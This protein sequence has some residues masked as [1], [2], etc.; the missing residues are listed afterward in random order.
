M[1]AGRA[2]QAE[3]IGGVGNAASGARLQSRGADLLFA[4][5]EEHGGKAVHPLLEQ[6]LDGFRRD[7]APGK[8]GA[9]RGDDYVDELV[10]DPRFHALPDRGD[11]VLDDRTLGQ[12]VAGRL[13]ALDQRG[14]RFIIGQPTR[15]GYGEYRDFQRHKLSARVDSA[16]PPSP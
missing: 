6:R 7:V 12:Y 9:A 1:G 2:R 16:H 15:V 10:V 13:D 4:D 8:A 11:V 14:A 5:E 3:N